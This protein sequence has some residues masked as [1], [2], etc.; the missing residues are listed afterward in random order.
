MPPTPTDVLRQLI[1]GVS[2]Q[3]WGDLAALYAEDAVVEQPLALPE[4]TRLEGRDA[5]AAHFAAARDMPIRMRAENIVIHGGTDPE[6]AVAEFEYLLEHH[7]AGTPV[8]A[9]NVQV[10]RVRDGLIVSS[11]DYHD[12]ARIAAALAD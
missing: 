3:R 11:R 1:D 9:A 12:H 10:A 2:E 5:I 4:R 7:A 6:L 8:R